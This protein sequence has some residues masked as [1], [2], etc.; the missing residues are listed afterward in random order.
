MPNGGNFPTQSRR[1]VLRSVPATGAYLALGNF[2]SGQAVAE[3]SHRS[4]IAYLGEFSNGVDGW[5]TT[6]GN[7]LTRVSED[8]MPV[9]VQVGSHALRVDI[10]GD[11]HP[12]IENKKEVK[13]ADFVEHPYL[14]AHVAGFAEETDSEMVFRFRLHH[15][16]APS[17]GQDN[18]KHSGGS[19]KGV[20]V[21]VSDEQKVAQLHPQHLRWDL[22]NLD[23]EIL[24]TTKRLEI[25]WYLED[26]PPERGHRGRDNGDYTGFAVFDDIRLT[27]DVTGGEA[28]ASQDKKLALHRKHGM[29]VERTYEER[30]E[31]LERGTLVFGDGTEIPFTFEVLDGGRFLYTID[32]E[33][34]L[35]GGDGR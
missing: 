16:A 19:G 8:E 15:T 12:M 4:G 30:T 23:E 25:V 34:F 6:G 9:G 17:D 31:E 2:A 28:K 32:G 11:L 29:V 1:N 14:L 35:L 5:K 13:E 21:E 3:E 26:H 27:N 24:E 20:L 33:S 7:K 22:T 10:D 18:G